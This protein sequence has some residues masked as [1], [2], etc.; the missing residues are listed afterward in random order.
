MNVEAAT[1]IIVR[2]PNPTGAGVLSIGYDEYTIEIDEETGI[3]Y[4]IYSANGDY[5]LLGC[6]IVVIFENI[7]QHGNILSNAENQEDNLGTIIIEC[8]KLFDLYTDI[9]PSILYSL[10]ENLRTINGSYITSSGIIVLVDED[11]E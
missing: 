11:I 10:S 8:N 9:V 3:G 6:C 4:V 1:I 2:D 5:Q 7:N